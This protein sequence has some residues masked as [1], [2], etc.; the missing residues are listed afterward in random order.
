MNTLTF[1]A[2]AMIRPTTSAELSALLAE[3]LEVAEDLSSQITAMENHL[4]ANA[5]LQ[6]A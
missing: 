6:A 4:A 5:K 1:N 3:A 2:Y